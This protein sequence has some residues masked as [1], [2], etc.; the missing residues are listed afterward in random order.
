MKTIIA[1]SMLSVSLNIHADDKFNFATYSEC[2]EAE[3]KIKAN[4]APIT[5]YSSYT[6]TRRWTNGKKIISIDCYHGSEPYMLVESMQDY[7]KQLDYVQ[8]SR[9]ARDAFFKGRANR[10]LDRADLF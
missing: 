4:Y 1:I 5:D 8:E 9:D 2:R 3:I 6:E 10:T 7:N